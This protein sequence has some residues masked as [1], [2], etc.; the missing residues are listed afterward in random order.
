MYPTDGIK[1]SIDE[2]VSIGRAHDRG[3]MIGWVDHHIDP[4]VVVLLLENS[5]FV[6][7]RIV[8]QRRKQK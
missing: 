3:E 5:A 4:L 2:R 6:F 1:S 7:R 8:E